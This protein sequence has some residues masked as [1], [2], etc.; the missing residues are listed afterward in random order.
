MTRNSRGILDCLESVPRVPTIDAFEFI[1]GLFTVSNYS[2]FFLISQLFL[3]TSLP[4]G[5]TRAMMGCLY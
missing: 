3:G 1:R 4:V 2:L 5:V